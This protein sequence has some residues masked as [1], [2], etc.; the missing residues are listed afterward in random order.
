MSTEEKRRETYKVY[1]YF[2]NHPGIL[3]SIISAFTVVMGFVFR[4]ITYFRTCRYLVYWGIDS[5]Y[6]EISDSNQIYFLAASCV[7]CFVSSF[8]QF[9]LL[10]S[11]EKYISEVVVVGY[12]KDI[13]KKLAKIIKRNRKD[14]KKRKSQEEINED[15]YTNTENTI[16][17]AKSKMKK[18]CL[19]RLLPNVLVAFFIIVVFTY[20]YLIITMTSLSNKEL[21]I[22][23]IICSVVL[24]IFPAIIEFTI[25]YKLKYKKY[26]MDIEQEEISIDKVLEDSGI[27]KNKYP[28]DTLL[29][30]ELKELFSDRKI[31]ILILQIS[32]V[33]LC[34]SFV[35]NPISKDMTETRKSF[36]VVT[37]GD[38]KYTVI[39]K[40][41]EA[42]Y[43][44]EVYINGDEIEI[45]TS[46]QKII[47]GDNLTYEN[48]KFENVRITD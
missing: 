3:L 28:L 46:K 27:R 36:S 48:M 25:D 29:D 1:S 15:I 2:K 9:F 34:M 23:S 19:K 12:L 47:A 13:Q 40:N 43:L 37:E 45:D 20:G 6:I 11:Y 5:Q 32:I 44:E 26:K 10:I 35:I 30:S 39:Y 38:V 21:L 14:K 18:L 31:V 41:N 17:E 24:S 4:L 8:M 42:Y 33:L 22:A 7:Y 16:K